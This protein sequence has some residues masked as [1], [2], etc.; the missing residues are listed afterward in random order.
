M[1]NETFH[2]YECCD[3]SA[4]VTLGSFGLLMYLVY[5]LQKESACKY[6]VWETVKSFLVLLLD[7]ATELD[8]L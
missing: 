2:A 1:M 4:G 7:Y 3:D 5:L 6:C 8:L